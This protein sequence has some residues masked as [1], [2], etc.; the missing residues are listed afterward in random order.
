M[1]QHHT[2]QFIAAGSGFAGYVL[3]ETCNYSFPLLA[4]INLPEIAVIVIN[5]AVAASVGLIVKH[6]F[7]WL[8]SKCR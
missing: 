1:P 6:S 8:K 4:A 5:S 2:E 3:S 7:D